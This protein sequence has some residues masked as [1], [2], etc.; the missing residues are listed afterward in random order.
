MLGSNEKKNS[1]TATRDYIPYVHPVC[2]C[3][4]VGIEKKHITALEKIFT[5]LTLI[6]WKRELIV[7]WPCSF[8]PD[9]VPI[10]EIRLRW[11]R[12]RL[13]A[14][15]FLVTPYRHHVGAVFVTLQKYYLSSLY[16]ICLILSFTNLWLTPNVWLTIA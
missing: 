2:I 10:Y 11:T 1:I 3:A 15:L 4:F 5:Q 6:V 13:V 16:L 12:T 8:I 7:L 14:R 9:I